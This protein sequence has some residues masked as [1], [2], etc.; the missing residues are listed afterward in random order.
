MLVRANAKINL[1]LNITGRRED[2]F[3]ELET[4]FQPVSLCDFLLVEATKRPG[5]FFSCTVPELETPDNIVC[6]AYEALAARRRLSGGLKVRL[7]KNI[8]REAGLGGGS[9]DAAAFL[10][11]ADAELGL[12]L[13]GEELRE[14]A[15][16]LGSDVPACLMRGACT[17][18]GRGEV[19]TP[20]GTHFS[21][22]LLIVK[23]AVSF[24]TAAMYRA[25][26]GL[27]EIRQRFTTGEAVQALERRDL[28]K[29]AGSLYN[30]F[31]EV[32]P[33]RE[34]ITR[35]KDALTGA[36]ALGSLMSGS[37]SAVF[38]IFD[39]EET[40][41]RACEALKETTSVWRA[42]AVND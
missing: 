21:Y 40:R 39:S 5:L 24:S 34:T 6:R 27:P 9:A 36:G 31:E 30:V 1:T 19:L 2:G 42:V 16:G 28:R 35:L 25:Y 38:G 3:H 22:P 32:V 17:G 37:G 20:V 14:L 18:G 15:E 41:D 11:G 10:R 12:G 26:D 23:P 33:E 29:L 8:P 7:Y 13:S 4:L